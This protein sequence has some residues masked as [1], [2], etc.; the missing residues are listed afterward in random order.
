MSSDTN[1]YGESKSFD[2]CSDLYCSESLS[3]D[4]DTDDPHFDDSMSLISYDGAVAATLRE[5]SRWNMTTYGLRREIGFQSPR[6]KMWLETVMAHS[7]RAK[8]YTQAIPK[9]SSGDLSKILKWKKKQKE[10]QFS[11]PVDSEGWTMWLSTSN[12]APKRP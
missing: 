9:C 12:G 8:L 10:I 2:D 6:E 11:I 5:N 1:S 7:V 4:T 3:S